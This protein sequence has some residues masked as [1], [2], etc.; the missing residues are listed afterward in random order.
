[1]RQEIRFTAGQGSL[2]S[3]VAQLLQIT[4]V[5]HQVGSDT[6]QEVW[7]KLLCMR[8]CDLSS[9]LSRILSYLAHTGHIRQLR[10]LQGTD[11]PLPLR[12]PIQHIPILEIA[13]IAEAA[14]IDGRDCQVLA[15]IDDPKEAFL[16]THA[17]T[18]VVPDI[19]NE[20][21]TVPLREGIGQRGN[22]NHRDIIDSKPSS[23]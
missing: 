5:G 21:P 20:K 17:E 15:R 8:P 3:R 7:R 9:S 23:L 18:I 19:G 10:L 16:E 1:G 4:R 14:V 2:H 12:L 13:P 11:E 22:R 6:K